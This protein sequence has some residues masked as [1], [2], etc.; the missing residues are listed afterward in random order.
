MIPIKK[1]NLYF[2]KYLFSAPNCF[3]WGIIYTK[4]GQLTAKYE[5]QSTIGMNG[6]ISTKYEVRVTSFQVL[7]FVLRISHLFCILVGN[8]QLPMVYF[9]I[10]D[11]MD[12]QEIFGMAISE[13]DPS[14]ECVFASDG[15]EALDKLTHMEYLPGCVFID[16]N[17][18]R[19]NGMECLVEIRKQERLQHVP[20]YIYS[21][22][23]DPTLI[24]EC[25]QLGVRQ[26]IVKPPGLH[27]LT[28]IL[29]EITQSNQR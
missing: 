17:M 4:I 5:L 21:T 8:S 20:V 26:F 28:E 9:F 3:N 14:I 7:Y 11:D 25:Q 18:P 23:A 13:V 10:D 1:R 24:Q 19:M 6:R 15:I 12:D 29:K 22:S 16:L 2:Q 27:L